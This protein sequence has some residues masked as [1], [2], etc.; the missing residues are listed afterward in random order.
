[1]LNRLKRLLLYYKYKNMYDNYYETLP[2]L[3]KIELTTIDEA[4]RSR[5]GIDKYYAR[6]Y[7]EYVSRVVTFGQE[8]EKTLKK[9]KNIR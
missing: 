5:L 4:E 1:M 6:K 9:M 7:K 2:L 3:T 8:K